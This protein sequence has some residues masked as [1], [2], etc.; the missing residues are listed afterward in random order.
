MQPDGTRTEKREAALELWEF[1]TATPRNRGSLEFENVHFYKIWFSVANLCIVAYRSS[2]GR[3]N[4]VE[5]LSDHHGWCRNGIY[6]FGVDE[7][8]DVCARARAGTCFMRTNAHDMPIDDLADT[9]S[10]RPVVHAEHIAT[11]KSDVHPASLGALAYSAPI[12]VSVAAS[13]RC[14]A[15]IVM[16]STYTKRTNVLRCKLYSVMQV[17]FHETRDEC[18]TADVWD[19]LENKNVESITNPIFENEHGF[20]VPRLV[21]LSPCGDLSVI[22]MQSFNGEFFVQI[23]ARVSPT[24]GFTIVRRFRLEDAL[25]N[26][27]TELPGSSVRRHVRTHPSSS[28]FSPCGRFLLVAFKFN[29][30]NVLAV[31]RSCKPGLCVFDLSDVYVDHKRSI[32]PNPTFRPLRQDVAWVECRGDLLPNQLSWNASGLWLLAR[33]G[34]LLLGF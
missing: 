32:N 33:G 12:Q 11:A 19:T 7:F 8:A 1:A 22:L 23:Y 10:L 6:Q 20:P 13:G 26:S 17:V 9:P 18:E 25:R 2:V 34:V 5:N 21:E 30:D 14:V 24:T 28:V 3:A 27:N 15:A 4:F 16:G 29:E 31:M